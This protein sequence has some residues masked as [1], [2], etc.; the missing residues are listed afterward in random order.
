MTAD[1]RTVPGA[2]RPGPDSRRRGISRR[3]LLKSAGIAG[4]A[5]FLPSV[6]GLAAKRGPEGVRE[7]AGGAEGSGN[8]TGGS[9]ADLA[10]TPLHNLTTAEA[11]ILEAVLDRLIPSDEHGPGALEAGVLG[12]IDR[13]LGGH[14]SDSREDYRTGLAALDRYAEYSRGAPFLELSPTD[15]DS[16]LFDVAGGGATATGAGFAG[17]SASFFYMVRGHALQGM[18]GDPSYGGNVDFAGWRLID[19]PGLRLGV[20][21]ETQ[22]RL[23]AGE[24]APDY[25]SAYDFSLFSR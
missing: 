6:G 4:A 23:E 9:Q 19:Y 25:R 16:V 17:S 8:G 14:L 11:E 13:A 15:Q 12:Y 22:R 5:A 2:E 20:S 18:F 3:K 7:P 24:L 1:D 21:A 10:A